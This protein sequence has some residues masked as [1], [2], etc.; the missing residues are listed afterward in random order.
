M[1]EV[2]TGHRNSQ[3]V[4]TLLDRR[5]REKILLDGVVGGEVS[6]SAATRLRASGSLNLDDVGQDID[7]LSDRVRIDYE[8]N[9]QRWPLGV[10]L[11][12]APTRSYTD[13]GSQWKVELLS[14]LAILDQVK[15]EQ[16]KSLPA[17]T[18][19][20]DAVVSLIRDCG[21]DSIALTASPATLSS[22]MTWE[23][24][25]ALLTI[26]NDLLSAISYW[27]LTIDGNGIYQIHP[28]TRPAQRATAWNFQE[29]PHSVHLAE[30][31]RD[32]DIASVPNRI[33]LV[34]QGS[35]DTPALVGAAENT[36]P[37]SP[38][39]YS[40]RGRWVT[41]TETG[42]EASSQDVLTELARRRLIEASTPQA[43]L[44]V[45]HMPLPLSP[46]EVVEWDSQGHRARAVIHGL[47]YTLNPTALCKTTLKEVVD[48]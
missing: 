31:D 12:A 39:S 38:F 4:V 29:G 23:P 41:R 20:T 26:I 1:S 30:W 2:L 40:A 7:W 37:A 48:L 18:V 43:T 27:S 6:L 21:E 36:D 8:G 44:T 33:V 9:G 14:K 19:V 28:Y 42:V 5:D 17:G 25:T 45:E 10:F 13:E 11:L 24:G 32:Q 22:A 46:N 3:Y 47:S 15:T 34:G 35:S 16:T